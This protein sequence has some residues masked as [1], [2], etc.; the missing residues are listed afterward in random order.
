M[1]IG[2]DLVYLNDP[3]A[4][5]SALNVRFV[6]RVLNKSEF[7][8]IDESNQVESF[9]T[10][11]AIKES[12][13]KVLVKQGELRFNNFKRIRVVSKGL[14]GDFISEYNG[15]KYYSSITINNGFVHAISSTDA[16]F[17]SRLTT[18]IA[19]NQKSTLKQCGEILEK[20]MNGL[21]KHRYSANG[22]PEFL[23]NNKLV[24]LSISHDGEKLAFVFLNR[25]ALYE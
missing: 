20:K 21:V 7:S 9:W 22:I 19:K 8:F 17:D 6:N 13:Y 1:R 12:I 10:L 4:I 25:Y 16:K 15:R 11:W 14:R 23:V 3:N 24:E 2:N 18:I 5:A